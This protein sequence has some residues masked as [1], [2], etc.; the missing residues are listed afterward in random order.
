[1]KKI[2]V[3]QDG[4]KECGA[5]CLLSIIK[6]YG[7][8]VSLERLLELTKTTKEG[9]NFYNMQQAANEIGLTS[10]GYKIENIDKLV[11]IEKPFISQIV[12]NNYTHFVV[13]YKIKND[14]VT[15]MD[16]AK[17]IVKMSIK[18]FET[19]WTSYIL[20]LEPYKKMPIYNE[21]NYILSIVK[22]LLYNNKKIIINLFSLTLIVTIFTCIYSYYFKVIIDN[23]IDTNK[24][25][26]LVITIIFL[27]IFIIKTFT[28]YLR[29]NLLLYLNEKIDLS[30]ITTTIY[31]I[32]SLPYNYYKNKTTGEMIS[33]INDLFYI[34]NVISKIIITIFL[35]IILALTTIIILFNINKIMSI[36]LLIIIMLYIIVFLI[37][38][39]SIKNMTNITQEDNAKINSQLVESISSY[40]TIKGLNLEK[41]FQNKINK[42]YLN[43]INNNLNFTRILNVQ[44]LFNNLFEGIILLFII[45]LG[46]TLIMD[47]SISIGSLITYNS[48]VYYFLTPIRTSLD[49]FKDL[50][51]VKNSI[52]RINNILNYKYE[53]LDKTTNLTIDGDI[54][55]NKLQFSYNNKNNILNN[56]SLTIKNKEKVL[57]LGSSG[58]GK[59]TLLKILY[60]YYDIERDKV[61][62]NNYDINDFSLQDIR[63]NITYISQ[64]ELLYNDTIRNNIIL[65][66]N[67][68]EKS[69]INVCNMVY[70]NEII[71]NNILSYNYVLEENGTNISGGQR[72]RIILARSLLKESNIILIDE[73]LNE[74]DIKLE[75][76]ILKNIF[77]YY[78]DKTIIIVSHRLENMDL[79]DKVI[80]I[81]NGIAKEVLKRN[82]WYL[83]YRNNS[84]K[85]KIPLYI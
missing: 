18:E 3:I 32:I 60:K 34:K 28:E 84:K 52:Q 40:E 14:K 6:Y 29:N 72:Q 26:L 36:Y 37:F 21:D 41:I 43:S 25:N 24:L 78:K 23:V 22:T 61:Y 57:I 69:Y 54:V 39:P 70:I 85:T 17:G 11:Q 10:K 66:R 47:K 82:E 51:Y 83:R 50:F 77:S 45:Y 49:F 5:A 19:I 1:M 46:S 64:N 20:I 15:I 16:P 74:I 7:G 27:L 75:R 48:L 71:K 58:S 2:T 30:I 63:K 67:I 9:T 68:D 79:Y 53:K 73:G 62:L 12:K 4:I 65:E 80:N 33:R 59:S 13:V 55:I 44:E 8:N 35:D 81:E 76:K 42:L 38:R 31:K 56:T